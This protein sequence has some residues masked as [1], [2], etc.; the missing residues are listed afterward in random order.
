MYKRTLVK[1]ILFFVSVIAIYSEGQ[2]DPD[3]V[4]RHYEF[5]DFDS[6]SINGQFRIRVIKSDIWKIHIACSREDLNNIKLRKN[7]NIF[8]ISMKEDRNVAL[9]SPVIIISMPELKG[10]NL[11]GLVQMEAGGFSSP[12]ELHVNLGRGAFLNLSGF[13]CST[14]TIQ[15]DGPCELRA[16]MSAISIN[17]ESIGNSQ[18]RIGGARGKSFN[19][20]LRAF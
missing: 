7:A 16:F 5:S 13:E 11:T 14:A 3:F 1:L 18:V 8:E 4:Q 15:L 10:L 19:P 2:I 6:L 9:R 20:I 12:S 17:F